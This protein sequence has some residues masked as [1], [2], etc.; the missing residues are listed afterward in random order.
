M[1]CAAY[2]GVPISMGIFTSQVDPRRPSLENLTWPG[3]EPG[4]NPPVARALTTKLFCPWWTISIFYQS[5]YEGGFAAALNP[6]K[7]VFPVQKNASNIHPR[8]AA[9]H[10]LFDKNPSRH[11]YPSSYSY[12]INTLQFILVCTSCFFYLCIRAYNVSHADFDLSRWSWIM[13]VLVFCCAIL[14]T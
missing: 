7:M 8:Q 6:C 5:L 9:T 12:E 14:F 1:G 13:Y 11:S 3:V 10:I 4:K 2:R